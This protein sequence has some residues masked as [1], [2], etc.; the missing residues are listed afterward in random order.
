MNHM[1]TT[2]GEPTVQTFVLATTSEGGYGVCKTDGKRFDLDGGCEDDLSTN[3]LVLSAVISTL[4]RLEDGT[5]CEICSGSAYLTDNI[6]RL[7]GWA[8]SDWKTK[9][10]KDVCNKALWVQI[11]RHVSRLN[12]TFRR[13]K[14]YGGLVSWC[15]SE[16]AKVF[17]KF[18]AE[19]RLRP[20]SETARPMKSEASS[21]G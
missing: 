14:A 8:A 4:Q 17:A 2:A 13:T 18:A 12:V 11:K 3:Q 20:S 6:P 7:D 21:D 9:A 15:A 5:H 16:M 19:T 10:N 1:N